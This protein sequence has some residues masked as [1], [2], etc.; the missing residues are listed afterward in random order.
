MAKNAAQ[1]R[2]RDPD[3]ISTFS[4][5]A[6][7]H[8]L[9][10]L[11]PAPP[12]IPPS[13]K[14]RYLS[15]YRY[16]GF[17]DL[18]DPEVLSN[19]SPF[20]IL[21][22]LVD[23]SPLEPVLAQ[24]LYAPSARGRTP[25]HPVSLFLLHGWQRVNNWKRTQTLANLRNPRYR[26]YATRFGFREGIYPSESGMRYF[27]TTLGKG[28]LEDLLVQSMNLVYQ[29]F[30][31]PEALEQGLVAVDGMIHDAA[32]RQRCTAVQESCYQPSPRPCPAKEKGRRGCDC[33]TPACA[34]RC[35]HAPPRDPEARYVWY[36]GSNKASSPNI[37]SKE[38]NQP[39]ST[40]GKE[41]HTRGEGRYGYR[42][43]SFQLCD[44][45]WRTNWVLSSDFQPAN[46]PE[47]PTATERLK[48]LPH[49][50]PWLRIKAVAGDSAFGYE[51]FLNQV[52]ALGAKRIIDLRSH[53]S[54][55]D[56]T[57]WPLRGYDGQGR[58]LCPFGYCLLA[59]GHDSRR[60]RH[61][62]VC[63]HTCKRGNQL[64]VK[65][66]GVN[67][68]PQGCPYLERPHGLVRNVARSFE[69]GSVRLVR[70]LPFGSPRWKYLYHQGRNAA[71]ARNS[72]MKAWDLKRLSVFGW[73]RS[74]ANITLAHLW[75][76]LTNL[77]RLVK[78]ATT[79]EFAQYSVVNSFMLPKNKYE[80]PR[81]ECISI[82]SRPRDSP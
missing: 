19:L 59:N 11:W 44:P 33:T 82:A 20:D 79:A 80:P 61:K 54:D 75:L 56:A 34:K 69:D 5:R 4:L 14:R 72:A 30:L 67:Y 9:P 46:A 47:E 7:S 31:S 3:F 52:Y 58:P 10:L 22:R 36:T 28:E 24:K 70:D 51:P 40:L 35:R 32:S 21:L 62:W 29:G 42:S 41:E 81:I 55:K 18:E 78:E 1:E 39:N 76:N 63:F 57:L 15:Q 73:E 27:E 64:R 23:F 6:L 74:R 71:E 77:A 26:D 17:Q 43:I 25:F 38:S 45:R 37:P 8:R 68:P 2:L 13:P 65:L 50:Y 66:E 49:H 60:R 48:K 16:L 53:D 12:D